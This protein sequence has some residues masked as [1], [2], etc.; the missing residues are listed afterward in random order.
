MTIQN[1]TVIYGGPMGD[2]I[3]QPVC[4]SSW[5]FLEPSK[6]KVFPNQCKGKLPIFPKKGDGLI[7]Q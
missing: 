3:L 1:Y 7:T 6:K 4:P 2:G 5:V